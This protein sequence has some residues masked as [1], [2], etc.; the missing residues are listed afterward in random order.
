MFI[1]GDPP[2]PVPLAGRFKLTAACAACEDA[3]VF[4]VLSFKRPAFT[5]PPIAVTEVAETTSAPAPGAL[6][7]FTI[8]AVDTAA[9]AGSAGK[10]S[11]L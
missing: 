9:A 8:A 1:E 2:R 6:R 3:R 10:E 7:A 4:A 5:L 11:V